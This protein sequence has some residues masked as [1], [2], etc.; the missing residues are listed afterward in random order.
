MDYTKIVIIKKSEYIDNIDAL[1]DQDEYNETMKNLKRNKNNNKVLK[2]RIVMIASSAFVMTALTV[3]GV[4]MNQS[5]KEQ[6]DNGYTMDMTQ[7]PQTSEENTTEYVKNIVEPTPEASIEDDLDYAQG[8]YRGMITPKAEDETSLARGDVETEQ[9]QEVKEQVDGT[10]VVIAKTL[11]FSEEEG[12]LRPVQGD[13]IM[14]YSMDSTIYFATLDQYKYN[15][16]TVISAKEGTQVVASADGQVVDIF[17]NAEVG[18]GIVL[19]LGDGYLMTYAQLRDISVKEGDYVS[20]GDVLGAVNVP[21]KYYSLE[22]SNLYVSLS[23]DGELCS[24]E[25]LLSE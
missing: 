20:T 17:N 19:D 25:E 16:A 21:T 2:E 13:I 1:V 23:R 18:D 10:E 6:E 14:H 9:A 5:A 22:G 24:L 3:T 15:P 8:T 4:Y 7:L 11:S 12:L